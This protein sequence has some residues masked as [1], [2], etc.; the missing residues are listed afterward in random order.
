[1]G[2]PCRYLAVTALILGPLFW[3]VGLLLRTLAVATANFTPADAARFGAEQF[4]AREQLAAYAANPAL[5]LA[6]Q[7]R[8]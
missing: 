1:M 2:K 4:A 5:T 8:S 7:P 3:C 6:G